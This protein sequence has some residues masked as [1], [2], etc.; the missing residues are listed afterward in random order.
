MPKC[1]SYARVRVSC[2]C[3]RDGRA[4]WAG[5][6]AGRGKRDVERLRALAC[7]REG[8]R[9]CLWVVL[10]LSAFVHLLVRPRMQVCRPACIQAC[11]HPL[12][13]VSNGVC[14]RVVHSYSALGL[15]LQRLGPYSAFEAT[16]ILHTPTHTPIGPIPRCCS[17]I[18]WSVWNGCCHSD[19]RRGRGRGR[20]RGGSGDLA[21]AA[22]MGGV[23]GW[24]GVQLLSAR[25]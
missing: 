13:T 6:R 24:S 15:T 18:P 5:G 16:G 4:R 1:T 7:S 14:G 8:Q 12:S 17:P 10:V 3:G 19:G 20:G 9:V 23:M 25:R 22:E 2:T 11:M 21:V